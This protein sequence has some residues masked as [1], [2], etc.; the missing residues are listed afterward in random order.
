MQ[1]WN[2]K[3][4][5]INTQR[6]IIRKFN[7]LSVISVFTISS[8]ARYNSFSKYLLYILFIKLR[9]TPE[10]ELLR[11]ERVWAKGY[12]V[13]VRR[14]RVLRGS[15]DGDLMLKLLRNVERLQFL[16]ND[17]LLLS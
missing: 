3:K 1:G 12:S 7:K 5:A 2:D 11:R 4:K 17:A 16:Q 6:E 15:N 9:T 10:I 14:L 8:V 13:P